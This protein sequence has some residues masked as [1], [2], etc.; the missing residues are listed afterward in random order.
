MKSGEVGLGA[1]GKSE[2]EREREGCVTK[3][4][5]STR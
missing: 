4:G 1:A 3:V 5:L 2:R